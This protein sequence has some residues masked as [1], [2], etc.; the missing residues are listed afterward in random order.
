MIHNLLLYRLYPPVCAGRANDT[1]IHN[2]TSFFILFFK[3]SDKK[4]NVAKRVWSA[5]LFFSRI[6]HVLTF[7]LPPPPS[8]FCAT[9][10][11]YVDSDPSG[12]RGLPITIIKQGAEPPTFIGWF[13]A[14]DAKMWDTDPFDRIRANF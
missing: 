2:H 3:P 14:W 4:Q 13:Q 5:K 7:C 9:A 12:R 6:L 10:K 8:T 1:L 11:E